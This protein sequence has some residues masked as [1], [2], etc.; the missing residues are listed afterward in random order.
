VR[1]KSIL[2][3]GG[4][5]TF[6]QAFVERALSDDL[7]D[8][9]VIFSRDE[10][11][12][13]DMQAQFGDSRL[14]FLLGDVRDRERLTR[15]FQGVEAVITAAA[16]KQIQRSGSEADEYYKT[17]CG[18]ALNVIE[19]AHRADVKK[20]VALSSDKAAA[21]ST[22][23]GS[24]K[25]TAEFLFIGGC[26]WGP[27]KFAMCRYGNILGSRGSV[28]E[29][30]KR[31]REAGQPLTLTDPEMTRFWMPIEHAV[32]LVLL[33]LERMNGGEIFIPKDVQRGKVIT[34]MRT[35]HPE[36]EVEIIG[37]RSYEKRHEV[38]CAPE[39]VDRLHDCGDVYVLTPMHVRWE[40]GPYGMDAPLVP[41]DFQYRSDG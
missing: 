9:I 16:L 20:V 18:G 40:P 38:L 28:L 33:A 26:I 34:L 5:G 41:A 1:Y 23:Y 2:I 30:W 15:A 3:T 39:E 22:P 35:A 32:D 4:T 24:F 14:R 8:R 27:A 29:I 12:Q 36:A 7:A 11:K 6:G 17:L 13:Q 31:Q 37:K 19:A 21:A 10:K 25:Y